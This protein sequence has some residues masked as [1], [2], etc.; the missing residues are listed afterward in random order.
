MHVMVIS[1][2]SPES[3]PVFNKDVQKTADAVIQEFP[4][5]LVKHGVKLVGSWSDLGAHTSWDVYETPSL[6]AFWA[7]VSEPR[8]VDWLTFSTC[9]IRMVNSWAELQA[10]RPKA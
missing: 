7:Y 5:L 4:E 10:L 8:M 6:D 2:H 1:T 3:C 9:E